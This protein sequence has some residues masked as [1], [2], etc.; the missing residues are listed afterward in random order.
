MYPARAVEL[1]VSTDQ[2]MPGMPERPSWA[3]LAWSK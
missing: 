1:E 3:R 2:S